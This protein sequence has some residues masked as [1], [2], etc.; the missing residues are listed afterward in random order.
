[1]I[2]GKE[3]HGN[4]LLHGGEVLR[5]QP[6]QTVEHIGVGPG[7]EREAAQRVGLVQRYLLRVPSEPVAVGLGIVHL[8]I[9]GGKIHMMQQH[10]GLLRAAEKALN[11]R[12]DRARRHNAL[13]KM[14]GAA[15]NRAC[16]PFFVLQAVG[17][18]HEAAHAVP[19]QEIRQLR[20]LGLHLPAQGVGVFDQ[21]VPAV[22][23]GKIA[24]HRG[25]LAMA[26][27]SVAHDDE[28]G[29]IQRLSGRVVAVDMLRHAVDELHHC[30]GLSLCR[31]QSFFQ[32]LPGDGTKA[33]SDRLCHEMLLLQAQNRASFFHYSMLPG[34]AQCPFAGGRRGRKKTA[35]CG[36]VS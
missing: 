2:S 13:P 20:I 4:V 22:L 27:M 25:V 12:D 15:E 21:R 17:A 8:L 7:R 29:L 34:K 18:G 1:M 10:T 24:L 6:A 11:G 33:S 31:P 30:F 35:P 3:Q 5:V 36:T 23:V 16:Q 19:Q 26:Q 14:A 9:I 28:T 32:F